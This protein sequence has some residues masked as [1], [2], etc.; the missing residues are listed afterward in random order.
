[1]DPASLQTQLRQL[2]EQVAVLQEAL[3]QS[4][5]ENRILRQKLD[6]LARRFFGK[7]SEQLNAAQ[8]EL[9]LS[10]LS[11]GPEETPAEEDPPVRPAPRRSSSPRRIRTPD[12]LEVV[13]EVLEPELVQAEPDQWKRIGQEV[14]RQLDYQP[15]K[16]FWQETVRPKYVRRTQRALPP[17]IAPAPERVADHCLAAPGLLAQ[18]LVSKYCDHLPFYRQEQ[19]FWRRHGVFI[20]RQQMVR[21]T[22]QSVGLL[23]GLWDGLKRQLQGSPYAQVDETPVRYQDRSLIGRC[24]QGYLWTALVP[25]KCVVYEWHP[26]RAARC[27]ETL[28][29]KEFTGK[30]QCDGY[31]AYPAYAKTRREVVLLGCWAHARRNFF[32]AQEQAPRVAGWILNQIRLLYGWEEELRRSRAGP[33]LRQVHRSSHHR[34]VIE[35]LHR[36]LNKLQSRYLPQSPMGQAISYALKQ[37]ALLERFLEHGEAE[38]DNNLVEN[39]I[40]PTAL[41]K[42]NWLFFGSE[43]A[44][45]RSA[46]IYTLI[47]NCRMHGV[48]PYTY[49]KDV[50][51]RLPSCTNQDLDQLTPLKWKQAREAAANRAA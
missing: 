17:V 6:A 45:Q 40:R 41:G 30:V 36:A 8:L 25:G 29:G 42:K 26:S 12:N 9:L 24:G 32:E 13:R 5:Q 37:W 10:G 3:E 19:I 50:L 51:E 20:A 23:Y 21:W 39:A 11:E 27:L 28:L 22:E 1:M 2:S 14:S 38:I 48:E 44:G 35:R 4:R 15:G 49:L 47:E 33:V 31:T 16:F 7:K 18:L 43:E 34:R 46:V